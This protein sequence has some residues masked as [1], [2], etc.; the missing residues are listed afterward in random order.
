[1]NSKKF[2]K[3]L[4]GICIGA[5]CLI[6]VVAVL[7]IMI[8]SYKSWRSYYDSVMEEI[9]NQQDLL[10]KPREYVGLSA[11]LEEGV[12]FYDNGLAAPVN[13]DFRVVAHFTE[14]GRNYDEILQDRA[15]ELK[16]PSNFADYGGQ[17]VISYAYVP[18]TAGETEPEPVVKTAVVDIAL[19]AVLPIRLVVTEQP[20]RVAYAE[21]M[22]FEKEGTEADVIYND[23]SVATVGAEDLTSNAESL[24]IGTE[25]VEVSWSRGGETLYAQIPVDV[26]S[27]EDYTDGEILS[28]QSEGLLYLN[29]GELLADAKPQIRATYSNGNR[30]LLSSEEYTVSGNVSAASFTKNCILTVR[31]KNSSA[32]CRFP[33]KVGNG[34]EAETGAGA[35]A[36]EVDSFVYNGESFSPEGKVT[37]VE[38]SG[39]EKIVFSVESDAVVKP[40]LY[41]RLANREFSEFGGGWGTRDILLKDILQIRVDGRIVP[42]PAESVLQGYGPFAENDKAKYVFEAVELP[43]I[44]LNKGTNRVEIEFIADAGVQVAVDRI[45]LETMYNGLIPVTM[46]EYLIDSIAEGSVPAAD[47]ESVLGWMVSDSLNFYAHGICTDGKYLY[48][49]TTGWGETLCPLQVVKVDPESGSIVATSARTGT[50]SKEE[51]AGITV[52]D[53]K[54]ILYCADGSQ[55]YAETASFTNGTVFSAFE[56]FHFAGLENSVI[57]D[58]CYNAVKDRFAVFVGNA[59]WVYDG[60]GENVIANVTATVDSGTAKRLSGSGDYLYIL[61]SQ[62]GM[63]QPNLYIYDWDLKY[64]GKAA[65]PAD[66]SVLGNKVTNSGMTNIQGVAELGNELYFTVVKWGA[67]NGGDEFMVYK[68]ALPEISEKIEPDLTIGEYLSVC[69]DGNYEAK[70]TASPLVGSNGGLNS[71][72]GYSMGICSDGTF[73]YVALNQDANVNATVYKITPT[74]EI[75]ASSEKMNCGGKPDSGDTARLF[76]KDEKL[77]LI[78]SDGTSY[79]ILLEDFEGEDCK[80]AEDTSVKLSAAGQPFSVY[81]NEPAEKYAVLNSA[82]QLNILDGEGAA[83]DTISLSYNGMKASSVCG[84]SRYIYVSYMVNNQSVLPVE[85][86]TWEGEKVGLIEVPGINLGSG[87]AYNI[88]CIAQHEG[89]IYATVTTWTGGAMRLY[90]WTVSPDH[91]V[92]L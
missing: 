32:Q 71:G 2:K 6:A 53:G 67:V 52:Y 51:F 37:V 41:L 26:K 42:V 34:V 46:Q 15:F 59:V 87:I 57:K 70:F 21:G 4:T 39:G 65:I 75:V 68:A 22:A 31:A 47:I 50:V 85:V 84:D 20:Y 56:G 23:G 80:F 73:L 78:R 9:E 89:Q 82:R 63:Y 1:M 29:E 14:K 5:A 74:G 83:L 66:S 69:A 77:F 28:I 91:S 27:Q 76:I 49:A 13:S 60:S 18:E 90:V 81:W 88:Q 43:D 30:L 10:G 54:L 44:L 48:L 72:E 3:M 45:D 11:E 36:K 8:P 19:Q 7:S 55:L 86:Y 40:S 17:V 25:S 38:P 62:N 24:I 61:E 35:E 12:E 79:S 16:V 33:A 64:I 92:Y 58:V